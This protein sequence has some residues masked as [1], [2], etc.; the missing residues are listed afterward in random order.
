MFQ[1]EHGTELRPRRKHLQHDTWELTGPFDI[2]DF[3]SPSAAIR[4]LRP[5]GLNVAP[6]RA[7][8][9]EQPR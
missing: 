3:S 7:A 8:Y 2:Q 5:R 6:P 1:G 4:S 9:Q